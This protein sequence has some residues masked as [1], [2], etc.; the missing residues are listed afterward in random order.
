M[1]AGLRTDAVDG[2]ADERGRVHRLFA[3]RRKVIDLLDYVDALHNLAED[4]VLAVPSRHRSQGDEE[5]AAAGIIVSRI[6]H[7]EFSGAVELEPGKKLVADRAAAERRLAAGS[8]I[9][10]RCVRRGS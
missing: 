5:L 4:G 10:G 1:P 7:G 3:A 2:H 9:Q 6:G 8:D